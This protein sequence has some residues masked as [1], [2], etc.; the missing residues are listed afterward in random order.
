MKETR[1]LRA[2]VICVIAI[3]IISGLWSAVAYLLNQPSD[4]SAL[5]GY[6]L[7]FLMLAAVLFGAYFVLNGLLPGR[8]RGPGARPQQTGP[9][10]AP[11]PKYLFAETGQT[12]A[13]AA[14][15][16]KVGGEK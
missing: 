10:S 7:I 6:K 8:E 4:L 3:P 13:E 5:L 11:A 16:Q 15:R 2:G 9:E 14:R 12:A 1:W